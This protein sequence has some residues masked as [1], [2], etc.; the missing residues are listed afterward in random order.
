MLASSWQRALRCW[1]VRSELRAKRSVSAA[2]RLCNR[3]RS[4]SSSRIRSLSSS[5]R[6][7]SSASAARDDRACDHRA[8][9]PPSPPSGPAHPPSSSS[10]LYPRSASPSPLI[11]RPQRRRGAPPLPAGHGGGRRGAVRGVELR[12]RRFGAAR[13]AGAGERGAE[14]RGAAGGREERGCV[15]SRQPGGGRRV[16]VGLRAPR[17]PPCEGCR[18]FREEG[19]DPGL[20]VGWWRRKW[21]L[22]LCSVEAVIRYKEM[23]VA[24]ELLALNSQ[25][26][27]SVQPPPLALRFQQ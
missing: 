22:L 10:P 14:P 3:P 13:R 9:Q 17:T 7:R 5:R 15:G 8:H 24:I 6:A 21:R 25:L 1:A 19:G 20:R 12:Q 23:V 18:T 4:A 16:G 26:S 11:A 27:F 2:M